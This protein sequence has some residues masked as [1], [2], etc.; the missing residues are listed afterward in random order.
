MLA[1]TSSGASP[2]QQLLV[3]DPAE[4]GHW[5][6]DCRNIP[7][8][9]TYISPKL[10]TNVVMDPRMQDPLSTLLMDDGWGE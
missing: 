3:Q 6:L 8:R 5:D 10:G 2:L 9:L 1:G 7:N 4:A